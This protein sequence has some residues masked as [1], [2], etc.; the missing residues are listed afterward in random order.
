MNIGDK[1]IIQWGSDSRW[2]EVIGF[3]RGKTVVGFFCKD[4]R[5][6]IYQDFYNS[7][8]TTPEPDCIVPEGLEVAV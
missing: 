3:D 6:R 1:V 4:G 8:M 5:T 7:E 2:G